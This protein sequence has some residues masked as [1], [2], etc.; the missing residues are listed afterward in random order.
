MTIRSFLVLLV[1]AGLLAATAASPAAAGPP[2]GDWTFLRKD[3]FRHYACKA[4]VGRKMRERTGGRWRIRT[5]TWI[6][7]SWKA[8]RYGIGAY[9]ALARGGNRKL[10]AE[11]T[12]TNWRRGYIRMW[13]HGAR[14]GDRLW[15]QGAYYGPSEPWSDGVRVA[16]ITRC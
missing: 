3:N 14:P 10:A 8:V 16:G 2:K 15:V 1:T 9:A 5:V 4:K 7:G 12:R 11:R 13:L 6:D